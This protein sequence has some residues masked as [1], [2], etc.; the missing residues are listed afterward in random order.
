[1]CFWLWLRERLYEVLI[2][3]FIMFVGLVV[4]DSSEHVIT[5]A[6]DGNEI[7]DRALRVLGSAMIAPFLI[8]FFQFLTPYLVVHVLFG[9]VLRPR[10]A[11]L[12]GIIHLLG[13]LLIWA[14]VILINRIAMRDELPSDDIFLLGSI[15][16]VLFFTGLIGIP[17]SQ[18]YS[19]R[20]P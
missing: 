5:F 8:M 2:G 19:A 20:K 3:G 4:T 12:R 7:D 11:K 15:I 14:T 18:F 1:M 10:N 16:Y 9:L 13:Y 6:Y 17:L